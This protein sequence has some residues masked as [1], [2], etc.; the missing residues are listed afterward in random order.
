MLHFEQSLA[1]VATTGLPAEDRLDLIAMIDDYVAGFVIKSDLEPG[2]ESV[3]AEAAPTINAYLDE[4][5][6]TGQYPHIEAL[7]GDGDRLAALTR[8]VVAAYSAD[9]RFERGLTRLLDGVAQD[10]ERHQPTTR[11]RRHS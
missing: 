5:L 1:A 2:L 8:F 3:P 9:Q 6:S 10:V 7:L 11:S 4:Q